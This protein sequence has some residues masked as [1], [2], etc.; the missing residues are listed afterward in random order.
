MQVLRVTC[1][2][3]VLFCT[4]WSAATCPL[5]TLIRTNS[6]RKFLRA[7]IVSLATSQTTPKISCEKF[8]SLT[9]TAAIQCKPSKTASGSVRQLTVS[10][11]QIQTR[12][13]RTRRK[14]NRLSWKAL[15]SGK[16]PFPFYP[17]FSAN[18][19]ISRSIAV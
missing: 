18:W 6:I 14:L 16:I 11:H 10:R 9:R 12:P 8:S 3:A 5:R 13:F 19:T 7:S 4:R 15:S 17:T 2:A 1:G